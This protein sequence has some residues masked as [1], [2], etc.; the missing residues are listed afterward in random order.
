[1][2]PTAR[3]SSST[4]LDG[5]VFALVG[6]RVSPTAQKAWTDFARAHGGAVILASQAKWE[7]PRVTHVVIVDLPASKQALAAALAA[8]PKACRARPG[9]PEPAVIEKDWFVQSAKRKRALPLERAFKISDFLVSDS[10]SEEDVRGVA[11][12]AESDARGD[13][14]GEDRETGILDIFSAPYGTS[15]ACLAMELRIARRSLERWRKEKRDGGGDDAVTREAFR[16]FAAEGFPGLV[17]RTHAARRILE[18]ETFPA[19]AERDA[20][21]PRRDTRTKRVKRVSESE[22]SFAESD[23]SDAFSVRDDGA[24][25]EA[26]RERKTSLLDLPDELLA[27]C[28]RDLSLLDTLAVAATCRRLAKAALGPSL[29]TGASRAFSRARWGRAR[30][31]G[32]SPP[33]PALRAARVMTWNLKFDDP[34]PACRFAKQRSGAGEEAGGWHWHV[35]VPLVARVIQ[36]EKPH[37]LCLQEDTRAM[38]RELLCA[39]E[40][41]GA[42]DRRELL[43]VCAGETDDAYD[44]RTTPVRYACFP[45]PATTPGDDSG[46]HGSPAT[47]LEANDDFPFCDRPGALATRIARESRSRRWEQCSVWWDADAFAFA[48]G[49]Q[50]EWVDGRTL[51][52]RVNGEA[53]RWGAR[54]IPFTWVKLEAV[55]PSGASADEDRDEGG[56]KKNPLSVIVCSAHLEAG[57]DWTEDCPAKRDSARCV[58]AAVGLLQRRF[59][60]RVPV[61]VAGDFNAQKTQLHRRLLTGEGAGIAR[62]LKLDDAAKARARAKS[63]TTASGE[64]G[65]SGFGRAATALPTK[66]FESE[67]TRRRSMTRDQSASSSSPGRRSPA[68]SSPSGDDDAFGDD[69]RRFTEALLAESFDGERRRDLVDVFDALTDDN[70]CARFDALDKGVRSGGHRGTTWHSW[71]GPDWACMISSAMAKQGKHHS[72]LTFF[73]RAEISEMG[74]EA[75]TNE[76]SIREGKRTSGS[77]FARPRANKPGE[78][79]FGGGFGG[80]IGGRFGSEAGARR[81]RGAVGHQRHIDHVYVARGDGV[82]DSSREDVQVRVRIAR[83]RVVTDCASADVRARGESL[84]ACGFAGAARRAGEATFVRDAAN[85]IERDAFVEGRGYTRGPPMSTRACTCGERGV[86]A[87]DHF[88]VVCDARVS[89]RAAERAPASRRTRRDRA[90]SPDRR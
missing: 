8:L 58:R 4:S 73:D 22:A 63:A 45:T 7:G 75:R 38:N 30:G 25:A 37:F 89:W 42:R 46:D 80:S 29:P 47:L 87:S 41:V 21:E 52:A 3:A 79:L 71:R 40:M 77:S 11:E 69:S 18:E 43:R 14:G 70:P 19:R 51:R 82:R 49:G 24:E 36:R 74:G 56:R 68:G 60:E 34:D 12:R 54:M 28:V 31:P 32:G 83:A 33:P 2:P 88:P 86:W 62:G 65:S 10:A 76:P 78:A 26:R 50:F 64:P 13:G 57:H 1:M 55:D 27:A 23:G 39:E 20:H 84:C 90:H 61:F 53:H 44:S 72:Q 59:G 66:G 9:F 5:L 48:D 81:A 85:E 6:R 17:G 67:K 15:E 35:R 16:D